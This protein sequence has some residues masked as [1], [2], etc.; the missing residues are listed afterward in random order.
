MS[1]AVASVE[2]CEEA[3]HAFA[4]RLGPGDGQP[5][6]GPGLERSL[7]CTVSDLGVRFAAR[8]EDGRLFDVRRTDPAE[9]PEAQIRLTVG[10]N[11]LV[12]LTSGNLGF[13]S[14]FASGR[15]KID[16]SVRDLLRLRSLL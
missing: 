12:A 10:S 1:G 11:D 3:L 6:R 2:A 7:V 5:S 14:A 8:L 9:T 4:V 16:A 13:T 15:I